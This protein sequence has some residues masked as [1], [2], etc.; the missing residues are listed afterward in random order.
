MRIKYF[1]HCYLYKYFSNKFIIKRRLLPG[2]VFS[3]AHSQ[4]PVLKSRD[5][6]AVEKWPV[7]ARRHHPV[8][9]PLR[10]QDANTIIHHHP[11][12]QY[13]SSL[14]W[15]HSTFAFLSGLLSV[16]IIAEMHRQT[17]IPSTF[18]M[19]TKETV[20]LTARYKQDWTTKQMLKCQHFV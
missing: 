10:Y 20:Y 16:I 4:G 13:H 18:Q 1:S 11:T 8:I 6:K 9:P 17:R 14:S 5:W 12:H 15:H 2:Q 19:L 3:K 7:P